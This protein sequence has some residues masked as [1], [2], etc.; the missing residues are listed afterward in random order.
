[1]KTK[2]TFLRLSM[3]A[4]MALLLLGS[5]SKETNEALDCFR[6]PDDCNIDENNSLE[7]QGVIA[8]DSTAVVSELAVE[9]AAA[10]E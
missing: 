9:E 7:L 8:V 2:S 6:N 1:M 3:F 5:C 4:Y 10:I